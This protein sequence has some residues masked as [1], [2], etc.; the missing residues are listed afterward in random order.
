MLGSMF[1]QLVDTVQFFCILGDFW[2][3]VPS[4]PESGVLKSLSIIIDLS[5]SLFSSVSFCFMYFETLLLGLY[6]LRI[7]MM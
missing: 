1:V 7:A 5:V 3:L 2:C 4:T 6:T